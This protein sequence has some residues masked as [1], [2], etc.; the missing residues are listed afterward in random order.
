MILFLFISTL[1]FAPSDSIVK[2]DSLSLP[3]SVVLIEKQNTRINTNMLRY[4]HRQG[5]FCDFEDNINKGRKIR[6]NIGVGE[7]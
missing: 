3:K 4:E 2:N 5:F 6:L 7:N 1:W